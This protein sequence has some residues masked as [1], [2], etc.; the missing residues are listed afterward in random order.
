MT[1]FEQGDIVE[2]NFN[3]TFGHE[4][5]KRRPALVVSEGYFNNVLSSLVVVCPITTNNNGHPLHIEI[6]SGNA[7]KGCV[8]TEAMR[9]M[10]LESPKRKVKHLDT[11]L[12]RETM[13]RVLE[14][15]GAVFN[16]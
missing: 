15:I 3:P 16:I 2:V 14:A 6:N 8:C 7:V 10:D 5:M 4:P 12:D 11:Q 9:A 13:S 1:R